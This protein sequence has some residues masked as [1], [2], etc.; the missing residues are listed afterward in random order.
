MAADVCNVYAAEGI[1]RITHQ[2]IPS[3][4]LTYRQLCN[5]TDSFSPNNLLGEGGFG[6]VYRGHL[7]EINEVR[8]RSICYM[9]CTHV[10][11]CA[12]THAYA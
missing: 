4:V 9:S 2:N 8:H 6:R 3:M 12:V 5:A 10:H 11:A 7:E 1:L